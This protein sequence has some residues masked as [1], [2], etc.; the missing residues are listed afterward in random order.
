LPDGTWYGRWGCNYIYGTWLVL[1]GLKSAGVDMTAQRY[2]RA[3]A[4]IVKHQNPDG[5]WGELPRSYDDPTTKGVGPSTPSQTAWALMALFALNDTASET[6]RR[7]VDYL[8]RVQQYDGSWKDA[9]WTGTGFP[10]VFYLRYHLYATYFPLWALSL[11]KRQVSTE[12]AGTRTAERVP[13][14]APA[15]TSTKVAVRRIREQGSQD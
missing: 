8:L 11:L 3:G 10:K 13:T 9:F 7:G 4:W 15:S 6:V 14:P 2:Q 1:R 12:R 5:G